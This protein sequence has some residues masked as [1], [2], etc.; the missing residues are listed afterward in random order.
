MTDDAAQRVELPFVFDRPVHVE[1]DAP[2]QSSDGGLV[3]LAA[4]D[5]QL[6]LTDA[7]AA[8]AGDRRQSAKVRH[9]VRELFRQRVYGIACGYPDCNDAATMGRDPLFQL[10]CAGAQTDLGSQPTLSRFENS[11]NSRQ[12]L[13]TAY[14]LCDAVL[15]MQKKARRKNPPRRITIDIDGVCDE[16]HGGQ[17]LALFNQHYDAWCYLPLVVSVAFDDEREQFVV[18]AFLRGGGACSDQAAVPALKRLVP[19]LRALFPRAALELRADGAFCTPELLS[20]CESHDL[21]YYLSRPG[22]SVLHGLAE[23]FMAESRQRFAAGRKSRVMGEFDY[24]AHSWD[25]DRRVVVRADV[26]RVGRTEKDNP[27]YVVTNDEKSAP[28]T[29]YTKYTRRGSVENRYKELRQLAFDRTSCTDHFANQFRY[30]ETVAAFALFQE[31]RRR[32]ARTP[33]AGLQV[34]TLRERLVK[35]GVRVTVSARRILLKAPAAF[36]WIRWWTTA[37]LKLRPAPS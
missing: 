9:S 12:L 34:A 10:A 2:A 32:L 31:L 21:V 7:M 24:A 19:R 13:R 33:A 23:P 30:L 28:V 14:A 26:C 29:I 1:F 3:L 8:A 5:R 15:R 37:A 17:Q 11:L 27:R 4:A 22:N 36:A 35:L 18:A 16:V 20:W 25:Q 6:G